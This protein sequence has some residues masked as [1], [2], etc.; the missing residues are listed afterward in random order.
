MP[1]EITTKNKQLTK[2]WFSAR[3]EALVKADKISYMDATLEL[4][5]VYD[6]EP[7]LAASMINESITQRIENEALELNMYKRT[8]EQLP[9]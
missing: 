5:E 9:V 4:C 6:I 7:A 1:L 8:S 2:E 3:V